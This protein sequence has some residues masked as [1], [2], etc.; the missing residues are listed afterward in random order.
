MK[1]LIIKLAVLILLI[2]G[3]NACSI[4]PKASALHD[5]GYSNAVDARSETI[6]QSKETPSPIT[7]ESPKWLEDTR[8]HYRLL[9][10]SPTQV[11]SYAIDR[12]IASPPELFEQLLNNSGKQWPR[13][14][15]VQLLTF[16]QQFETAEQ[17]KVVMHFTASTI[18]DEKN[19]HT[20]KRD[21]KLHLPCPSA[22]AKG[23]VTAFNELTRRATDQI[24]AWLLT[25]D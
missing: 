12:W 4:R 8:I 5:L 25:I 19:G 2:V 6:T 24:Q 9:F 15:M 21:F 13:P 1:P 16:E 14:L 17:A 11:R 23:A 20:V 10:S 7:V 22:D 18:P 3:T